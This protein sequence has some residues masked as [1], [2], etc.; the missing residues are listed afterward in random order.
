MS[1]S[2]QSSAQERLQEIQERAEAALPGP[3]QWFGN[4]ATNQVFLGTAHSGRKIILSPE[5]RQYEMVF[6]H[7]DSEAETLTEARLRAAELEDFD[8]RQQLLEFLDE[9]MDPEEGP[10]DI[11]INNQVYSRYWARVPDLMLHEDGLMRSYRTLAK[12]EVLNGR[13]KAEAGLPE[14]A[15]RSNSPLY[16]EDLV[17]F[18]NPE[19]EFLAH[20]RQDVEFLL[21]EVE[22][23][24]SEANQTQVEAQAVVEA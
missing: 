9:P 6:D 17:G 24:R 2:D 11:A 22:R 4:T 7:L 13:S 5:V 12:Y 23:L 8:Q 21:S 3:W 14:D 10:R 15:G 20:A 18:D 16:R 1:D 19:A